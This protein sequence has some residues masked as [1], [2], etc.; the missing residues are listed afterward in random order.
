MLGF[1]PDEFKFVRHG[2]KDLNPLE[3]FRN[4][5]GFFETYQ[6]FQSQRSGRN[7]RGSKYVVV[8]APYH[9]TQSLFLGV[10][11][12]VSDKIGI[13]ALLSEIRKIKSFGWNLKTS[14]YH[15]LIHVK[16]L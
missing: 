10:W 11:Q 8:F 5:R 14:V 7:F 9:G 3:T 4:D 6:S 1:S 2:Y 13:N 12:V 16:E 15:K